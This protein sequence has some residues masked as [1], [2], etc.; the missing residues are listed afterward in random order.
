MASRIGAGG[1]SPLPP[2]PSLKLGIAGVFHLVNLAF[3]SFGNAGSAKIWGNKYAPKN[4]FYRCVLFFCGIEAGDSPLPPPACFGSG[5]PFGRPFFYA[6]FISHGRSG[7]AILSLSAR[8]ALPP[9]A[10]CA[11]FLWHC[12][13]SGEIKFYPVLSLIMRRPIFS[14]KESDF[15]W[16]C[17]PPV[18]V[19]LSA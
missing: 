6:V 8:P 14:F 3:L 11:F 15:V 19:C 12:C 5:R 7:A 2:A 17:Y 1:F 18:F 10:K 9:A 16:L 4:V 13:H